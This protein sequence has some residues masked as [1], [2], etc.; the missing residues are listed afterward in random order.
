MEFVHRPDL[1][2]TQQG[3]LLMR[4]TL[5]ISYL[6]SYASI[7]LRICVCSSFATIKLLSCCWRRQNNSQLHQ[8]LYPVDFTASVHS[9]RSNTPFPVGTSLRMSSLGIPPPKAKESQIWTP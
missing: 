6:H 4:I 9:R 1:L 2:Y 3:G 7:R 8:P 5:L